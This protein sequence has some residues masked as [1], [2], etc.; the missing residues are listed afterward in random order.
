MVLLIDSEDKMEKLVLGSAFL[1]GGGGGDLVLGLELAKIFARLGYVEIRSVDEVRPD[2]I[3][4]TTSIVGPQSIDTWTRSSLIANLVGSVRDLEKAIGK[5]IDGLIS[6]EIGAVNTL[7]PFPASILLEIPVIDA[8]CNGRAHPTVL[9]GSMGL[10]RL[11]GYVSIIAARWGIAGDRSRGSAVLKGSLEEV[12]NILRSIVSMK[13][14]V[15]TA[16]NPI[17][18]SYVKDNGAPGAIALAFELGSMISNYRSDPLELSYR[19]AEK[20]SGAVIEGCQVIESFSEIREG[21]DYGRVRI[22]CG[23]M[24]YILVYANENIYLEDSSGIIAV[25]PDLISM[26][27][28]TTGLPLLSKDLKEGSRF[29]IVVI[30]WKKLRLGSGLRYPESYDQVVR[31]IGR[32]IRVYLKEL[33]VG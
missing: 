8:P 23:N 1:G 13:G 17:Y 20:Y 30:R 10:Q 27:D 28:L 4:V 2:A 25:F 29:N 18:I 7:S 19:I 32:D 31:A 24:D 22:K 14:V 16:R 6:S 33:L 3:V 15:A 21:L 5:P 12:I 11:S 9:M 26:I